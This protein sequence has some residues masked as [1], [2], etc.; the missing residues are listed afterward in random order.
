MHGGVIVPF[1]LI[2]TVRLQDSLQFKR[3]RL[4]PISPLLRNRRALL[5]AAFRTVTVT[6]RPIRTITPIWPTGRASCPGRKRRGAS[7][8]QRPLLQTNNTTTTGKLHFR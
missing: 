1:V 2:D 8:P 4:G 3:L 5:E 6:F 7:T